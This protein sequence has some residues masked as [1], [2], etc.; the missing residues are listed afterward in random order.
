MQAG[1][2]GPME[3]TV[4]LLERAMRAAFAK[5]RVNVFLIDGEGLFAF[6]T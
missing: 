3:V 5:Q 4:T 6:Y 1:R 2:I